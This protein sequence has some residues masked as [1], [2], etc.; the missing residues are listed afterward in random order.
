MTDH[1]EQL[2]VRR[3]P[4]DWCGNL[5]VR[6]VSNA[7]ECYEQ[8]IGPLGNDDDDDDDHHL[9]ACPV[10]GDDAEL[11]GAPGPNEPVDEYTCIGCGRSFL[12][13]GSHHVRSRAHHPSTGRFSK[14][15]ASTP[16]RLE[17][18]ARLQIVED[19]INALRCENA[20]LRGDLAAA[21]CR[22][23]DMEGYNDD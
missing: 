14:F 15:S 12:S 1:F 19:H 2:T 4:C 21:Y 3:I 16:R 20:Q 13:D 17:H 8:H 9:M 23:D 5:G 7:T 10:C 22:M 18:G 11:V 6:R